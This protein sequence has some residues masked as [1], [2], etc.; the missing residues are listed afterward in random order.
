M[1]RFSLPPHLVIESANHIG[2]YVLSRGDRGGGLC[3]GAGE[4]EREGEGEEERTP[5][6]PAESEREEVEEEGGGEGAP[7]VWSDPAESP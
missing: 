4:E 6:N 3:E 7:L 1:Q 5:G 2:R